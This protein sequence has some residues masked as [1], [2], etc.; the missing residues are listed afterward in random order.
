M[1]LTHPQKNLQLWKKWVRPEA[2]FPLAINP[3]TK[4]SYSNDSQ[5]WKKVTVLPDEAMKH[6]KETG[7]LDEFEPQMMALPLEDSELIT[8]KEKMA[9]KIKG[10]KR[11]KVLDLYLSM[12]MWHLTFLQRQENLLIREQSL[13]STIISSTLLLE[14]APAMTGSRAG[15]ICFFV[16]QLREVEGYLPQMDLQMP[17]CNKSFSS[18]RWQRCAWVLRISTTKKRRNQVFWIFHSAHFIL[19]IR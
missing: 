8:Y 4:S 3:L 17:L 15:I 18:V 2:N 11:H 9:Y 16:K 10:K 13:Y 14:V 19:K 5:W 6:L 12:L 7:V 1:R